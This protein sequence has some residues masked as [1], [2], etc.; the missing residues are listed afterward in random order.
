[1]A[2]LLCIVAFAVTFLCGRRSLGNGLIALLAFGYAY[3]IVRA[4]LPTAAS[5]FIFDGAALG[6][7]AAVFTKPAN[8]TAQY[9]SLPLQPWLAVLIGW[10]LLMFFVPVQDWTIQLV[11]LRAAVFFLPFM[12][13]GARLEKGDFLKLATG[14]AVLNIG[15]LVIAA[16]EFFF[17]IERF[18]PHNAVTVLISRS[19]DLGGGAY[20]IPGTFVQS[21]AYGGMMAFTVPFLAGAWAYS[22]QGVVRRR[23]L[24]VGI[25]AAG[26]GVFMSGSRMSATLFFCCSGRDFYKPTPENVTANRSSNS[27]GCNPVDYH[28]GYQAPTLHYPFGYHFC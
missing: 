15:E 28:E 5:H 16:N 19:D 26:I 11:G 27:L 6:L 24:E 9:Q 13:I 21:A 18:F 1:M 22:H 23:L 7:Y 8:R 3:G 10:P 12:L 2:A 25:M 4:N 14:L 17:G 20:R